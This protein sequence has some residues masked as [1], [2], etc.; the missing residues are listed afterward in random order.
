MRRRKAVV[1]V[2]NLM[3]EMPFWD[4][5]KIDF[6]PKG[7]HRLV[8]PEPYF[9]T[10]MSA[11]EIKA[12]KPK[13]QQWEQIR[14]Y[15]AD[16]AVSGW[17]HIVFMQSPNKDFVVKNCRF[18]LN[19]RKISSSLVS[20][21]TAGWVYDKSNVGFI[22]DV[23]S[24][25]ILS[26][27]S[28]DIFSDWDAAYVKAGCQKHANDTS[29]CDFRCYVAL[30]S[31]APTNEHNHVSAMHQFKTPDEVIAEQLRAVKIPKKLYWNELVL[32]GRATA[33]AKLY[34]GVSRP[35]EIRAK[36]IYL[37]ENPTDSAYRKKISMDWAKMAS[38]WNYNIP[39]FRVVLSDLNMRR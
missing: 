25:S 5:E 10:F 16:K 4:Q 1:D 32:I 22:L 17:K 30:R 2:E 8:N 6:W 36:G 13:L 38:R 21:M 12:L 27:D 37:I 39:I 31:A 34:S 26:T 33:H 20:E 15:P 19:R 11:L 23:P 29:R 9:D 18:P 14:H 3:R 35:Q 24:Q 7:V 28:K